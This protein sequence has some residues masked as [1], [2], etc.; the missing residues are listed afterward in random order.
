MM[1]M[2]VSCG[3]RLFVCEIMRLRDRTSGGKLELDPGNFTVCVKVLF[4]NKTWRISS[5]VF[6]L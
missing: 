3:W 2:K 1:S 6:C 4:N 5:W